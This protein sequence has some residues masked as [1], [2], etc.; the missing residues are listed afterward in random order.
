MRKFILWGLLLAAAVWGFLTVVAHGQTVIPASRDSDGDTLVRV[1]YA[2]TGWHYQ[3]HVIEMETCNL[4]GLYE[5]KSTGTDYGWASI[6][7]YNASDVE[8]TQQGTAD[9]DCVKTQVDWQPTI[10]VELV[11]GLVSQVENPT[12]DV[13]VWVVGAPGIPEGSGGSKAFMTG[14][15]FL[16][17]EAKKQF[18]INGRSSKFMAYDPVY[19][20]NVLRTTIKTVAGLKHRIQAAFEVYKQ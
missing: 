13:R 14:F 3:V 10:D 11:G 1:K 15:N 2:P 19:N 18:E 4:T 8:I 20:S 5:K 17:L 16:F 9:T 6:K 7:L 12:S